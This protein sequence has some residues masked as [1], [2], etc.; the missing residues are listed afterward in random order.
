MFK[1]LRFELGGIS[2]LLWIVLFLCPFIDYQKLF[3]IKASGLIAA[4]V[5]SIVISLP[6]GNYIHQITDS[7]FNPYLRKR[8]RLFNRKSI[9]HVEKVFNKEISQ[10]ADKTYQALFLLSQ[11][12]SRSIKKS[13]STNNGIAMEADVDI[14]FLRENVRNRYSYYYARLE[15]GLFAPIIG[16]GI[17]SLIYNVTENLE[18]I[19]YEPVVSLFYLVLAS[20]VVCIGMLWRIPQLF[21]ELDDIEILLIDIN[22]DAIKKIICENNN[23]VAINTSQNT[24]DA[25]NP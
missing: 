17:A 13:D 22:K 15:N 20:I 4:L 18:F 8:S 5:G 21:D 12:I 3:E 23:A 25:P 7:I 10:S 14:A 16:G 2:A 9:E 19:R 1:F 11:S 6:L 24:P